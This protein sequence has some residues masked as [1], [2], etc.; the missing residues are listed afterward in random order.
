MLWGRAFGVGMHRGTEGASNAGTKQ[1]GQQQE[2]GQS[3]WFPQE[4]MVAPLIDFIDK[5]SESN[6]KSR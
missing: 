3:H 1:A 5:V 6:L 2:G 4:V